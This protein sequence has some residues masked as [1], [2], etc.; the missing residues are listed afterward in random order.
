MTEDRPLGVL[1]VCLGNICRSPLAEAIFTTMAHERGVHPRF[2][3]DSCGIGGW[4]EGE[5]AD[6]RTIRVGQRHGVRVTS[7]A[8]KVR[9]GADFA[10]F[11]HLIAMDRANKRDLITLGA[12][13][14]R[15]RLV[16]SFDPASPGQEL[17]VPDPYTGA[18]A[19]FLEVFRQLR[20]SCG[21]LLDEL[22]KGATGPP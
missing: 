18:D 20:A 5:P 4:H 2:D 13:E 11:H 14:S 22:L 7:I 6:H 16:R 9:P 15:V 8:R 17:D 12:P 19:D 21:G 10:R 1:F 3:I